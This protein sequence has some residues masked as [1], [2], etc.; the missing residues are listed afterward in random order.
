VIV[1]NLYRFRNKV[2]EER[3]SGTIKGG[4]SMLMKIGALGRALYVVLAIVAAF[5]PL[6]M[7]NVPLMLVVLGIIA[8]LAMMQDKIVLAGVIAVALPIIG[9]A[10]G[11]I[12][13]VGAQLTAVCGN[14][15]L[16]VAGALATAVAIL[17]YHLVM[18]GLTGLAGA[19]SGTAAAVTR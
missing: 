10:L 19:A 8:G 1:A 15:Q 13:A 3:Q 16:G 11:N 12:P 7:M 6:A 9:A 5:V 4:E 17:L 14:L 2:P 18:D